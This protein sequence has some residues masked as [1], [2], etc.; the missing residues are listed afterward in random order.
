M[1]Q[2]ISTGKIQLNHGLH[3]ARPSIATLVNK[4]IAWCNMQETNRFRWLAIAV[5]GG[6]GTVL[7]LTLLAVVF[8]ADN[9]FNLWVT[10]C[11]INVPILIV[12][13]AVQPMKVTLPVLFFAW[14]VDAII[15]A[16]C[17]ASFF[18]R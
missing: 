4:F 7:P 17:V 15:I 18:V 2:V 16:Y 13:L 10:A 5:A 8:G 1:Q 14:F 11:V 6:I 12:S 3:T 9:N